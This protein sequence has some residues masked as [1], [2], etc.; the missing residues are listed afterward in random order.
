MYGFT[1]SIVIDGG[2]SS[3]GFVLVLPQL[4][5]MAFSRHAQRNLFALFILLILQCLAVVSCAI[6]HLTEHF[7]FGFSVAA[8]AG[9]MIRMIHAFIGSPRRGMPFQTTFAQPNGAGGN[10]K[11]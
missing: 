9:T 8:L 3:L 2:G 6:P 10:L 5:A 7:F 1:N 4:P 11:Q